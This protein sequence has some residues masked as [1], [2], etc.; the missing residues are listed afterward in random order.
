MYAREQKWDVS[1]QVKIHVAARDTVEPQTAL[2]YRKPLSWTQTLAKRQLF[3]SQAI[4][5]RI[6]VTNRLNCQINTKTM[7]IKNVN[8]RNIWFKNSN[9]GRLSCLKPAW[10]FRAVYHCCIT[11]TKNTRVWSFCKHLV[12]CVSAICQCWD[13]C[14]PWRLQQFF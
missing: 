9:L 11:F 14:Q 12:F 3:Y 2:L 4:W 7:Y 13:L 1:S 8:L 10:H 6:K 5:I